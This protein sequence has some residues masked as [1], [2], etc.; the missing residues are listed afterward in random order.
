MN[1][2]EKLDDDR[3]DKVNE[4][5]TAIY[6]AIHALGYSRVIRSTG[7]GSTRYLYESR[8]GND[9]VLVVIRRDGTSFDFGMDVK[10]TDI[11]LSDTLQPLVVEAD[12]ASRK[13][14]QHIGQIKVMN[15]L[16]A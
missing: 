4:A 3:R 10:S 15:V 8:D 12:K 7:S 13:F 16:S 5:I 1:I 2:T 14:G 6:R 9:V 11:S